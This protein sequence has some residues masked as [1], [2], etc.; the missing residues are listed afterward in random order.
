M[1]SRCRL[2]LSVV[3]IFAA[4]ISAASAAVIRGRIVDQ[5]NNAPLVGASIS[6]V[7]TRLGAISDKAGAYSIDN[8]PVGR[9]TISV[10]Y[11]GYDTG[12]REVTIREDVASII[13]DFQL[14]PRDISGASIVVTAR[15]GKETDA[16]ARLTEKNAPS[17]VSVLS[18]QTIAR[19]PDASTAE[20]AK[21][22]PGIS[23]TR[24][25]G[26]AREAIVRGMEGRYN[27]TL[28]DGVKV[29]SPSTNTR[30][31]QLDYLASD[32]LQRIEV[33]KSLT[34]DME[35]DAIG[36]SVNLVM[37]TAPAEFLLRA[38]LGIGYNASLLD[39]DLVGFRTDSVLADPLEINGAG[40]ESK[41][42]DF[43]RDNLKL[44]RENASPDLIGEL[45][46]GD[47]LLDGRLG[48]ILGASV[49]KTS[50]H[51][52]T[53]RNYDG[54]DPD[55]T[56]FLV[57]RQYRLHGH[58]KS[59][60]GANAKVDYIFDERNDIQLSFTGFIRRNQETRLINDTNLVYSP[61]LY[62]GSRSVLQTYSLAN[63]VLSGHNDL[64]LV[65]VKWR[66][67]WA[68][69][70]QTKPDRA[71]LTTSV[72]LVGDSVV[73][74]PVLY[75]VLRDW[76]HNEDRDIFGGLDALWKGLEEA[77]ITITAGALYRTKERSNYQ[78]EYRLSP[79]PDAQNQIP[80]FS[81]IDELQW[82]VLNTGGTPQYANNNYTCSENV[83]GAY[84]MGAWT[85]GAWNILAGARLE[86]TDARYATFDV[87][88]LAQ[89]SALKTY[90]DIL[91]SAHIRYELDDE[92]N[93]RLSIGQTI[94]R[95]GYF[96][97]VPYNFI[98]EDFREKGNPELKRALST[99][100]DLRYEI[101]P[102]AGPRFS[103]GAFAKRIAD[104]IEY[105]L[106]LGDPALPTIVARNLGDATNIGAEVVAE[107]ELP[108]YFALH[109][110]YTYTHSAITTNKILNDRAVGRVLTLEETRPLQGQSDHIGNLALA[111]NHPDWGTFAQLSFT[112]TG[113]RI[114]QV[115]IYKG[116]DHYESGFPLLD[117]SFEHSLAERFSAFARVTNLLNTPYEV[118]VPNGFVT[119]REVFGQTATIGINYR[120]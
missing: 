45:T 85:S 4:I 67:G 31:V 32:L 48:L 106:D 11:V 101:I 13:M 29:P 104:P 49:Q 119:E 79:V 73:S 36:G 25:R 35:A 58:V 33:T 40:Y 89:V 52:E 1:A 113:R 8:L 16:S 66:G 114:A 19:Y 42:G 15:S 39:N 7:G 56:L 46:I 37:R 10:R 98:G 78:N 28:I 17:V 50:Q 115:S 80:T 69:A 20:I 55:N 94:S 108:A 22:I 102:S 14:Q 2:L 47:R 38:R 65:E 21:R 70:E 92:S 88:E 54:V 23:I 63:I 59:K 112:Y 95:P 12:E 34:P 68:T 93:L 97:V 18:A 118:R 6:I 62:L 109:A 105:T 30:S 60:L 111:F 5:Q 26:E 44:T 77:G 96:D 74:Q 117:F 72:A 110:N 61:V 99:N 57:R 24:V 9:Y 100:L 27:N 51:S 76:Q 91:P 90:S 120:Y 3:A 87:N 41:P 82:A 81:S 64:G 103:L 71:E 53:T 86:A 75:A 43:T 83:L 116:F 107:V 84:L